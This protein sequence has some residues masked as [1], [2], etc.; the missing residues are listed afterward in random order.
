VQ[1]VERPLHPFPVLQVEEGI[2][3]GF[4]VA[5]LQNVFWRKN[6]TLHL[7][8]ILMMRRRSGEEQR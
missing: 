7:Q 5:S 4:A 3:D 2:G 1:Q 8:Q 6:Q